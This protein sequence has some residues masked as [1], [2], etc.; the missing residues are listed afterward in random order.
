[1]AFHAEEGGIKYKWSKYTFSVG[2]PSRIVRRFTRKKNFLLAPHSSRLLC[3]GYSNLGLL[4]SLEMKLHT[5]REI[6]KI[7]DTLSA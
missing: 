4:G 3:G 2:F 7:S 1:M 6:C 5:A